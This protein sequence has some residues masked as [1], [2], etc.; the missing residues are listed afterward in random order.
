MNRVSMSF[1]LVIF[2]FA[3]CSQQSGF[4]KNL[5]YSSNVSFGGSRFLTTNWREAVKY[6]STEGGFRLSVEKPL[7]KNIGLVSGIGYTL[8]FPRKP[9][10][11]QNDGLVEKP[12]ALIRLVDGSSETIRQAISIPLMLQLNLSKGL[13]LA[14]I[15]LLGRMWGDV[16][17]DYAGIVRNNSELGLLCSVHQQLSERWF[18]GL[19]AFSGF[20]DIYKATIGGAN[21]SFKP[22]V[23][24]QY[25]KFSVMYR[26]KILK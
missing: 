3:V 17:D 9:Y 15:G 13:M 5:D 7:N 11:Y 20:N 12:T 14:R 1:I 21:G 10:F 6:P 16:K 19:E 24:N 4:F 8:K 25:A 23:V 18:L 26:F 2:H 22:K